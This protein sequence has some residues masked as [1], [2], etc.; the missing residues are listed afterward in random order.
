MREPELSLVCESR[1]HL[2]ALESKEDNTWEEW[3]KGYKSVVRPANEALKR[4]RGG[5]KDPTALR[6][7]VPP[8][9]CLRGDVVV[10]VGMDAS[11]GSVRD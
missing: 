1:Q 6:V 5:Q 4:A 7:V 8:P 9:V 11:G 3:C 2:R 10:N